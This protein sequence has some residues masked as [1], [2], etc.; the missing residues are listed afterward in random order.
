MFIQAADRM[1]LWDVCSD[2]EAV[3]LVRG[4]QDPQLA[5]KTLVDHALA[6]FSTDNLSC[7]VVRFDNKALKQRKTEAQLGV[8][9]DSAGPKAGISEADAIVAQIK[10]EV[11]EPE[12]SI[13][14]A[15]K[16]VI[17]EEEGEEEEN[18]PELNAEA[19]KAARKKPE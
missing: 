8:D 9:R 15:A 2:Q 6:R 13:E 1:Q 7:M 17:R 4:I 18:G 10:K 11:G 16:Q 14:S 19:V 3:D 12:Q 5:S